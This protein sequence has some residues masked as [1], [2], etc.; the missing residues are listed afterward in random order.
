MCG[1][2]RTA[3]DIG[4]GPVPGS[5]DVWQKP[6]VGWP[7]ASGQRQIFALLGAASA[8]VSLI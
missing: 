5:V 1:N 4:D 6:L 7:V 2:D 3:R 8:G